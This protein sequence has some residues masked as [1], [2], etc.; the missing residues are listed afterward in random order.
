VK[1]NVSN[2]LDLVQAVYLDAC[3]K[4]IADVSDLRDIETI[5]S[6]VEEEGLSFLTITLPEFC[7][8]FERSLQLGYF[9]PAGFRYFH[10]KRGGIPEFLRGILGQ[11][12]DIETGRLKDEVYPPNIEAVRQI[13][14][15][16]KKLEV[17]CTPEREAKAL[18]NFVEVE[19]LNERFQLREDDRESFSRVSSVLWH[20][21]LADIQPDMFVPRHGPGATAEGVRGNSKY[22]WQRWYE[23]LEPYFPFFPM[24]YS[25]SAFGEGVFEKVTFVPE[26]EEDPVRVTLVPKTLK[27]PRVIAIEPVCMQYAQQAVQSVLVKRIERYWLTR[28]HVNFTDQTVNQNLALTSSK[29][30]RYATID[31]SDA[32]DRVL[33]DV[34]ALV[35]ESNPIL[36]DSIQACRSR[37]AIL[38]DGRLV[39]PLRKFASMGS[40][41]C[42]PV[43]AM[44]FYTICVIALLDN[45]NLPYISKYIYDVT[46][47]IFVYGDDLIVPADEAIAVLDY[48]QKYHCKVNTSKTF[49][50]G[51]FRESCGVD[52]YDGEEV[53]PTY[54]RHMPPQNR[55][56][57]PELVSWV[58]T[59]NN[60]Y[61]KGYWRAASLM[62]CTCERLLGE[63]P[64]VS[65]TSPGL[66]RVSL[67]GYR[68]IGRWN[69]S[70]HVFEEKAWTPV[71]VYSSDNIDGY[72]ALQKC[73]LSLEKR[74]T[75]LVGQLEDI[76]KRH[77]ERTAL[78]GAIA[79]QRRWV[80]AT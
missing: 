19:Q 4:C 32:S 16:F 20:N 72:P 62:F 51:K 71:T 49:V 74:Q 13:C 69:G 61:R 66:G 55:Q 42:F 63:L 38:P 34:A 3:A 58:A 52:A 39:S 53:T 48:L 11:I 54:L 59:A 2:F 47:D 67:L 1:R 17:P 44:V 33:L 70:N 24:C 29:T 8:I 21:M 27:A 36:W 64:Y 43:E 56:Q 60:F 15:L 65:P 57:A 9:D 12:F 73:L 28:G 35:F 25:Y 6:R 79:L 14:L 40:A 77:L 10:R 46:R 5:E 30:G 23:R 76:D 41:L 75:N 22:L 37:A 26:E 45:R 50:T 18:D 78:R 68:S 80:P 7:K 31:L